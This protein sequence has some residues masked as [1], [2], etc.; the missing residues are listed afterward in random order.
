MTH[1]IV[2]SV[3]TLVVLLFVAAA[4]VF[5]LAVSART[6]RSHDAPPS[7]PHPLTAETVVCRACHSAAG[8]SMPVTHRDFSDA[9]CTACHTQTPAT[10][11]PHTEAMGDGRCV[12]C[13]GDPALEYGM[14]QD[15]LALGYVSCTF[16]HQ[17][18]AT[19]ARVQPQEAG[20]SALPAPAIAHPI[21]GAFA[22]C[23]HCHRVGSEPSLPAS[24]RAFGGDTCRYLCHLAGTGG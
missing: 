7:V 2:T 20:V 1:R 11:V 14:P 16:C 18:N 15:H 8:G 23:L 13:H 22:T 4:L 19:Q 10:R 24:H 21:N 9:S 6:P 12:L 5:A 17:V 3:V